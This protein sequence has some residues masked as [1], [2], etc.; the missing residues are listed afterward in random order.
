MSAH[1]AE[2]GTFRDLPLLLSFKDSGY[3][4][5]E[6]RDKNEIDKRGGKHAATHGGANCVHGTHGTSIKL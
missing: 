2:T 4:Y 1:L 6:Q 5:K 3:Q